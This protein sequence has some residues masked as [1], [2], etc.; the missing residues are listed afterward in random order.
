MDIGFCGLGRMGMNMVARLEQNGQR[1]VAWNRSKGK[2]EALLATGAHWA[3]TLEDLAAALAP[4]RAVWLMVPAETVDEMIAGIL[5]HLQRGDIIIDGGNSRHTDT[6]R[7]TGEL[8]AEGIE[9]VDVGTSGGVW[10]LEVGYCLMVGGA[11]G[12]CQRLVPVF[13][14]LAPPGGYLRCGPSGAGH[15]VKMVHNGIEYGLMQAYAEGF[16]LL[17]AAGYGIDLPATAHLWMQGSVVRSWLLELAARALERDP[18]LETVRGVVGDSGEGRWMVQDAVDLGVPATVI[19]ASLFKRFESRQ[20]DA[21]ANRMLAV[22]RRE[23]GGHS[24]EEAAP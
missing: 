5:P 18:C 4:P 15:F 2:R 10:G 21:F 3:E 6:A 13:E 20:D 11:A 19:A 16:E 12:A 17:Q 23:F 8:A 14:A 9:L 22:L 1:V 24:V 7:R